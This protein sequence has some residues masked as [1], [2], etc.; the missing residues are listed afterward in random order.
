VERTKV[1]ISGHFPVNFKILLVFGQIR[2]DFPVMLSKNPYFHVFRV[3]R[4]KFYVYLGNF[5]CDFLNK[6]K[7]SVYL[8][9]Q[10]ARIRRTTIPM[11]NRET[12]LVK[13]EHSGSDRHLS[14]P[15]NR[16]TIRK[17]LPPHQHIHSF[18]CETREFG[19]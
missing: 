15:Y 13:Q 17:R 3:N 8:P 1:E 16:N 14:S 11:K 10:V 9:N 6:R 2:G 5:Q 18:C 7:F 12:F 4:R 19:E